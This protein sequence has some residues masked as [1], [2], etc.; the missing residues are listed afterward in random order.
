MLYGS[1][2]RL[3]SGRRAVVRRIDGPAGGLSMARRPAALIPHWGFVE[4]LTEKDH[5][6]S[7]AKAFELRS[8]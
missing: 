6:G 8:G 7:K 5:V 1:Q 4:I 3:R 2:V